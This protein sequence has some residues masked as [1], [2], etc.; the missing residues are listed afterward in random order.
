MAYEFVLLPRAQRDFDAI[1]Q[2]LAIDLAS[3]QAAR[4]FVDEFEKKMALVCQ[5]PRLYALSRIP[6][7]GD[8]GYRPMPVQRYV[9]LYSIRENLIVVAHI[10]HQS[11]DYARYV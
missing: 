8:R 10:F 7:I 5:N 4:H 3:P 11:Q 2:Y 1:V 9:A 6:E